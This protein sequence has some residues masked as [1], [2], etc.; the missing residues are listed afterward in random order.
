M[1]NPV[2]NKRDWFDRYQPIPVFEDKML[3]SNTEDHRKVVKDWLWRMP[4]HVWSVITEEETN[5]HKIVSGFFPKASTKGFYITQN[6]AD[7]L[8]L[9]VSI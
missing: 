9:S 5:T 4:E 2:N 7:N 8:R 3:F 1:N 6:P